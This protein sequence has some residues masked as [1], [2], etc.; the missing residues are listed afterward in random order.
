MLTEGVPRP[1]E[2]THFATVLSREFRSWVQTKDK[3]GCVFWCKPVL[4]FELL[5]AFFEEKQDPVLE[6]PYR[7]MLLDPV[8]WRQR[9][10]RGGA[11]F[12]AN[13]AQIVTA[14]NAAQHANL[15]PRDQGADLLA[16]QELIYQSNP[17][18]EPVVKWPHAPSMRFLPRGG[19][20]DIQFG[21]KETHRGFMDYNGTSSYKVSSPSGF[22]I[23]KWPPTKPQD[24]LDNLSGTWAVEDEKQSRRTM[25]AARGAKLLRDGALTAR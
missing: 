4:D 9:F 3:E 14:F 16:L 13:P 2:G 6:Q 24:R 19:H 25:L 5:S 18:L 8:W 15:D 21:Q 11:R 20:K 12:C 17:T 23:K 7:P 22:R 1:R 10:R